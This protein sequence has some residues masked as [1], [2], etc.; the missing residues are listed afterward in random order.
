MCLGGSEPLYG[1]GIPRSLAGALH[2]DVTRDSVE[3][4][5]A[6]FEQTC[7]D[8]GSVELWWVVGVPAFRV[9]GRVA[10]FRVGFHKGIGVFQAQLLSSWRS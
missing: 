7:V 10:G 4:S 6:H 8:A 5:L 1:R 2:S 9:Q 3:L